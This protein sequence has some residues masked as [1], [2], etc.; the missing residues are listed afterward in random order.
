[1]RRIRLAPNPAVLYSAGLPNTLREAG[2]TRPGTS[3]TVE[4][5]PETPDLYSVYSV[6]FRGRMH[7]NSARKPYS[8]KAFE[9]CIQCIQRI[10]TPFVFR[11]SLLLGREYMNTVNTIGRPEAYGVNMSDRIGLRV[12]R[13]RLMRSRRICIQRPR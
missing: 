8:R 3:A 2:K 4:T 6:V 13:F 10:L 7:T 1:M 12:W 9:I 11:F 5:S